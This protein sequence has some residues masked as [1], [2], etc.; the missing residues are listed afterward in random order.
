MLYRKVNSLI[1]PLAAWNCIA[2]ALLALTGNGWPGVRAMPDQIMALNGYPAI[3]P[4]YFLRDVFICFALAPLF[5]MAMRR[6]VFSLIALVVIAIYDLDGLLFLNNALPVF[7]AIGV[8]IGA[9]TI[10]TFLLKAQPVW[11]GLGAFIV[12]IGVIAAYA[13]GHSY[14]TPGG[15]LSASLSLAQRFAG[16]LVLWTVASEIQRRSDL[17]NPVIRLEPFIFFIFC[18]H[19]LIVSALW[20]IFSQ[21]GAEPG[22]L[23]QFC[24][25]L[26]TPLI[27]AAVA[28]PWRRRAQHALAKR[29]KIVDGRETAGLEQRRAGPSSKQVYLM[30]SRDDQTLQPFGG[31]AWS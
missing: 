22:T 6:P 25:F 3:A 26:L 13:S 31:N 30:P 8:G 29:A 27:V 12:L 9:R 1:I 19:P 23:M 24:L 14:L 28:V 20:K 18:S 16:S 4:L 21:L 15:P 5:I 11:N 10:D 7:F 17:A 2:V